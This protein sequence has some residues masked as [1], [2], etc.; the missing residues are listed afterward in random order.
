MNIRE[1]T[2]SPGTRLF[3]LISGLLI[4]VGILLTGIKIVHWL[5]FIPPSAF[6][7]AALTGICPGMIL[8]KKIFKEQSK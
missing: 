7:L 2:A 1:H 3:L 5:L 8:S 4:W 6:I